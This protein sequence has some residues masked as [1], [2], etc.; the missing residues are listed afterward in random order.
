MFFLTIIFITPVWGRSN[1]RKKGLLLDIFLP[2]R[3]K[4]SLNWNLLME[5]SLTINLLN[6]YD[7]SFNRLLTLG[8][9]MLIQTI[10][11]AP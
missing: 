8:E 11:S 7:S 3:S 6:C 9:G 4:L 10:F 1:L 5:L 2:E